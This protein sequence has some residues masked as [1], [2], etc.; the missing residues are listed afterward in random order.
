MA[1]AAVPRR[2]MDYYEELGVDRS[3]SPEEIRQAYKHLVRLLHPDHCSDDAVRPLADLQMKRLNGLLRILT[4]PVER[5]IYDRTVFGSLPP[6]VLPPVFPAPI[7]PPLPRRTPVWFWHVAGGA[8]LLVLVVLL[9]Y[10][11]PAPPRQIAA[12]EQPNPVS[13]AAPKKPALRGL[14]VR[15][16]VTGGPGP[17]Q[18]MPAPAHEQSLAPEPDLSP[19]TASPPVA[20]A[21]NSAGLP[22]TSNMVAAKNQISEIVAPALPVLEPAQAPSGPRLSGVWL[23]VPSPHSRADGLYPPEY[24]ELRLTEESGILHGRYR[25][26]YH[27]TDQ[28]ISPTVAFQFEGRAS[29]DRA[30]LPWSGAGGARGE[31]RVR[32]V[33]P[34]TLEVIWVANQ[35]SEELG[36]ISGT[37]TLVRKLD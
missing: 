30:N 19:S 35:L 32:L 16:Q 4:N 34:E 10:T 8:T 33:T 15:A 6:Q 11:P 1:A 12:P 3:A 5:E 36:L 24:I 20:V 26:R 21:S 25:A 7:P 17:G 14:G 29:P 28:A 37:A 13:T 9:A 2:M 27:I 23:L 31:I 18:L 22:E